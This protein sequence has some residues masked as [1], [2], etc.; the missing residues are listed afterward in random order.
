MSG[1]FS[2]FIKGTLRSNLS[3][4]GKAYVVMVQKIFWRYFLGICK[5]VKKDIRSCLKKRVRV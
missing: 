4:L 5:L 3:I 2:D 1:E